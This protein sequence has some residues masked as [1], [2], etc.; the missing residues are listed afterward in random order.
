MLETVSDSTFI[1]EKIKRRGVLPIFHRPEKVIKTSSMKNFLIRSSVVI[2]AIIMSFTTVSAVGKIDTS[3]GTNGTLRVAIGQS[4]TYMRDFISQPEGNK[5][6]VAGEYGS[7]SH[8][9]FVQRYWDDGSA[10]TNWGGTG[11]VTLP[12]D[13]YR[14]LRAIA[15]QPDGKLVGVGRVA[16]GTNYDFFIVRFTITGGLD[17][18][19]GNGG[20]VTINQ[21]REDVFTNVAVQ[22]NGKI[23]ATGTTS[24]EVQPG[25]WV[26]ITVRMNSN[27]TLDSGFASGGILYHR[28]PGYLAPYEYARPNDL[29]ILNDGRILTG[30][31]YRWPRA[32]EDEVGHYIQMIRANGTLDSDFAPEGVKRFGILDT[33]DWNGGGFS[34]EVLPDGKV[35]IAS[36]AGTE[37]TDFAGYRK[38]FAQ[39]GSHIASLPGGRFVV[40]EGLEGG[41]GSPVTTRVRTYSKD[42]MIGIAWSLP[43]GD[44]LVGQPDGKVLIGNF[45]QE[46][47]F[48][49]ITRV[50]VTGSQ[51]T[52]T[53]NFIRDDKTDIAVYRPSDK[54]IYSWFPPAVGPQ[55]IRQTRGDFTKLFPEFVEFNFTNASIWRD[56]I[57]GWNSN[58]YFSFERTA[59]E[60]TAFR[61][62]WGTTGDI[63]Y[64]GD[65]NGDGLLD[66][67]VFRPA[68]GT[69]W[70][71]NDNSFGQSSPTV[72]WGQAGDKPVPADYD[73][74]GITD[75]AVYRPS[76]GTWWIRKSSDGTFTVMNFGLSTDIPLTGDFDGDGYADLTVYRPSEG[77]WYQ[78][79]TSEGFRYNVFGIA[80]DIPV[81]GDYDGDG[82]TD[83]AVYRSGVWYMLQSTGGLRILSWGGPGDVPITARYD[84]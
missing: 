19:F 72:Q 23:I 58:G 37:V 24:D 20:M 5:I 40:S 2:T 42:S 70:G 54:K 8:N 45:D 6:Y 80:T 57:V 82:K 39:P 17:T 21:D 28:M 62:F 22:P 83:I 46:D 18:T 78:M 51:G 77:A 75:Y 50:V 63:A 47:S 11:T 30:G 35:A 31:T 49:T 29:E 27:G 9:A 76:N 66:V 64:G 79:L 68:T 43:Y 73:Y 34:A 69:W 10:D 15:L 55:F 56:A 81:P 38:K 7:A 59:N 52:R 25:R 16:V 67:G 4:V 13:I 3:Y 26:S 71:L 14:E 53:T 44:H 74:D 65:F 48:S 61:S 32:G 33:L 36:L 1:S 12:T 60:T 84:Q 41:G